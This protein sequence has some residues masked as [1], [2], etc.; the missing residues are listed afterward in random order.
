M[1]WIIKA[2]MFLIIIN[3]IHSCKSVSQSIYPEHTGDIDFDPQLDKKDFYLCN[4]KRI[5][6]YYSV[7]TDYLGER[8]EIYK[9][10]QTK[11]QYDPKHS[12]ESGYM[13]IR[14]IVN[15]KGETDRFRVYEID[16]HY[17]LKHFP[18]PLKDQLLNIA[19]S[20]NHWIPG[21]S[22]GVVYDSYYRITIKLV[23]GKIESIK[24]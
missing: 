12:N 9:Q 13:T 16:E 1:K 23:N 2:L 19:K 11:Y 8:K 6:Q 5:V 22:E 20:L 17:A 10:F 7:K 3:G 4:D 18:V 14:F 24:P 15:C 21:K